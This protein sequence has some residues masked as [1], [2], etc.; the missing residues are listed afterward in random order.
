M[1]RPTKPRNRAASHLIRFVSMLS[2]AVS[3]V[4][5]FIFMH[6]IHLMLTPIPVVNYSKMPC[7]MTKCYTSVNVL[8]DKGVLCIWVDVDVGN[9]LIYHLGL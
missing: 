7:N 6:S 4:F 8:T 1:H 3:S 2:C 5:T 9:S